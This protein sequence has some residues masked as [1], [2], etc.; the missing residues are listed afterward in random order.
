MLDRGALASAIV[1]APFVWACWYATYR[2]L[3]FDFDEV[4]MI[5]TALAAST[6]LVLE[7]RR[8]SRLDEWAMTLASQQAAHDERLRVVEARVD[9]GERIVAIEH[10][11][12]F[13]RE[14]SISERLATIEARIDHKPITQTRGKGGKFASPQ[15]MQDE[16]DAL[17]AELAKRGA[18]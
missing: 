2:A 6:V 8:V 11:I 3:G 13:S 16:I 17:R 5:C 7:W 4:L 1:F 18:G 15:A 9:Y 14:D 10:A 12:G